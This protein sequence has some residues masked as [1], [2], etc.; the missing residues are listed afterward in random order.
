M[1]MS[2]TWALWRTYSAG[3]NDCRLILPNIFNDVCESLHSRPPNEFYETPSG[4][5][6]KSTLDNTVHG[7]KQQLCTLEALVLK[8]LSTSMKY[9]EDLPQ[10][11][12]MLQKL[13][14]HILVEMYPDRKEALKSNFANVMAQMFDVKVIREELKSNDILSP[15][16]ENRFGEMKYKLANMGPLVYLKMLAVVEEVSFL[17]FQAPESILKQVEQATDVFLQAIRQTKDLKKGGRVVSL[18]RQ[19]EQACEFV[20]EGAK[21]L[22]QHFERLHS[23]DFSGPLLHIKSSIDVEK[24]EAIMYILNSELAK[25][26]LKSTESLPNTLGPLMQL[27]GAHA[28]VFERFQVIAQIM[29]F[30]WGAGLSVPRLLSSTP[31]IHSGFA[32]DLLRLETA[33]CTW[34]V[35]SSFYKLV[36]D[37]NSFC[38]SETVVTLISEKDDLDGCGCP[39]EAYGHVGS[40]SERGDFYSLLQKHKSRAAELRRMLEGHLKSNVAKLVLNCNILATVQ[41]HQIALSEAHRCWKRA[42]SVSALRWDEFLQEQMDE[43]LNGIGPDAAR[44]KLAALWI[45]LY[46]VESFQFN[47]LPCALLSTLQQIGTF[48]LKREGEQEII[49]LNS[50]TQYDN[51]PL[52]LVLVSYC[53]EGGTDEGLVLVTHFCSRTSHKQ[54]AWISRWIEKLEKADLKIKYEEDVLRD[55]DCLGK[56]STDVMQAAL[57]CLSTLLRKLCG[58]QV[59]VESMLTNIEAMQKE[60]EELFQKKQSNEKVSHNDCA[61]ALASLQYFSQ[62]ELED[63]K[64]AANGANIIKGD[65]LPSFNGRAI[66]EAQD[67]YMKEKGEFLMKYMDK[68]A[69]RIGN[70]HWLRS[71]IKRMKSTGGWQ[72]LNE[73]E[74]DLSQESHNVEVY[75]ACHTM[76]GLAWKGLETFLQYMLWNLESNIHLF[77]KYTPELLDFLGAVLRDTLSCFCVESDSHLTMRSGTSPSVIEGHSEELKRLMGM[78]KMPPSLLS[79][80]G[81]ESIFSDIA[82][83]YKRVHDH[84][85]EDTTCTT[86]PSSQPDHEDVG[87]GCGAKSDPIEDLIGAYKEL[88]KRAQ[89]MEHNDLSIIRQISQ[90]LMALQSQ[91][92]ADITEVAMVR[93]KLDIANFERSLGDQKDR[94]W[95]ENTHWSRVQLKHSFKDEEVNVP[96]KVMAVKYNRGVVHADEQSLDRIRRKTNALQLPER[97]TLSSMQLTEKAKDSILQFLDMG[98][99]VTLWECLTSVCI[100][101][102]DGDPIQNIDLDASSTILSANLVVDIMASKGTL[103]STH[104]HI[105]ERILE[106]YSS[107]RLNFISSADGMQLLWNHNRLKFL[108]GPL[109]FLKSHLF[110]KLVE[111]QEILRYLHEF[112]FALQE[113]L[114]QYIGVVRAPVLFVPPEVYLSDPI[115]LFFP[116]KI[117]AVVQCLL[118]GVS[119]DP[120]MSDCSASFGGELSMLEDHEASSGL[121]SFKLDSENGE[122]PMIDMSSQSK[123]CEAIVKESAEFVVRSGGRECYKAGALDNGAIQMHVA[124]T[125]IS[126]TLIV[127]RTVSFDEYAEHLKFSANYIKDREAQDLEDQLTREQRT[128]QNTKSVLEHLKHERMNLEHLSSDGLVFSGELEKRK[129]ANSLC[130]LDNRISEGSR[131]CA[132]AQENCDKLEEKLK[133]K[134]LSLINEKAMKAQD[135]QKRISESMSKLLECGI[136]FLSS[137]VLEHK[138]TVCFWS[139][140]IAEKGQPLEDLLDTYSILV[141]EISENLEVFSA[142]EVSSLCKKFAQ[143]SKRNIQELEKELLELEANDPFRKCTEYLLNAFKL[144]S[145]LARRAI[146]H[147]AAV[148]EAAMRGGRSP[149]GGHT[150]LSVL[151]SITPQLSSISEKLCDHRHEVISAVEQAQDS[152]TFIDAVNNMQNVLYKC[153]DSE[154]KKLLEM[155]GYSTTLKFVQEYVG[156]FVWHHCVHLNAHLPLGTFKQKLKSRLLKDGISAESMLEADDPK[157]MET[158]RCL[159]GSCWSVAGS[160]ECHQVHALIDFPTCPLQVLWILEDAILSIGERFLP[161]AIYAKHFKEGLLKLGEAMLGNSVLQNESLSVVDALDKSVQVLGMQIPTAANIETVNLSSISELGASVEKMAKCLMVHR[162]LC[163]KFLYHFMK[164]FKALEDELTTAC[165]QTQSCCYKTAADEIESRPYS[166]NPDVEM[167]PNGEENPR[168]SFEEHPELILGN[169]TDTKAIQSVL[170]LND[171]QDKILQATLHELASALKY[172]VPGVF[173]LLVECVDGMNE[174]VA[175]Q[176]LLACY[177]EA[178]RHALETLNSQVIGHVGKDGDAGDLSVKVPGP[179][180]TTDSVLDDLYGVV[181]GRIHDGLTAHY[182]ED[183]Q[184]VSDHLVQLGKEWKESS[185]KVIEA[186][187]EEREGALRKL[188]SYVRGLFDKS[189]REKEEFDEHCKKKKYLIDLA[190]TIYN[191]CIQIGKAGDINSC[192]AM[193]RRML[194]SCRRL[195][196]SRDDLSP[197]GHGLALKEIAYVSVQSMKLPNNRMEFP[198]MLMLTCVSGG[199]PQLQEQK[200]SYSAGGFSAHFAFWVREKISFRLKL[201]FVDDNGEEWGPSKELK[202]YDLHPPRD[203][204]I[205][206]ASGATLTAKLNAKYRSCYCPSCEFSDTRIPLKNTLPS[207]TTSIGSYGGREE[208]SLA[209][210]RLMEKYSEFNALILGLCQWSM[211]PPQNAESPYDTEQREIQVMSRKREEDLETFNSLEVTQAYKK[212]ADAVSEVIAE[213]E[214]LFRKAQS[215]LRE[216]KGELLLDIVPEYAKK[217][218]AAMLTYQDCVKSFLYGKAGTSLFYE[219]HEKSNRHNAYTREMANICLKGHCVMTEAESLGCFVLNEVFYLV[220]VGLTCSALQISSL[221]DLKQLR[222]SKTKAE[223][224]FAFIVEKTKFI[225]GCWENKLKRVTHCAS[226][227]AKLSERRLQ[228][229]SRVEDL[230]KNISNLELAHTGSLAGCSFRQLGQVFFIPNSSEGFSCAPI[231]QDVDFGFVMHTDAKDKKYR[232][233]RTVTLVNK[234]ADEIFVSVKGGSGRG[235]G[236]F[237]V[238]PLGGR[239]PPGAEL[240]LECSLDPNIVGHHREAWSIEGSYTVGSPVAKSSLNLV[241]IVQKLQVAFDQNAVDFGCVPKDF[242]GEKGIK[243]RN[244]TMMPLWVKSQVQRGMYAAGLGVN[245]ESFMLGPEGEESI[246]VTVKAGAKLGSMASELVV[247]IASEKYVHSIPIQAKVVQPT[248]QLLSSQG[249]FIHEYGHVTLPIARYGQTV[250]TW[251]TLE[252][253]GLI[254]FQFQLDSRDEDMKV[255]HS[256]ADELQPAKKCIINISMKYTSRESSESVLCIIVPGCKTRRIRIK[257]CDLY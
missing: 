153:L 242:K 113:K 144:G 107:W 55:S 239:L 253:I 220:G 212:G 172:G 169:M 155:N 62:Q 109:Q 36:S 72:V 59:D 78:L 33:Y 68:A 240:H 74:R 129:I 61:D 82:D 150:T 235:S 157:L 135:A 125:L 190:S 60:L 176:D 149:S 137:W 85:E 243:I 180:T 1:L 207:E 28:R 188:L 245:R 75:G 126:T 8:T 98:V 93:Y 179:L 120:K 9:L 232:P 114:N 225:N 7:L 213:H 76:V 127:W 250:E 224:L 49:F 23:V 3:M 21:S 184:S 139:A 77:W 12:M 219:H 25:P 202:P 70:L 73:L 56:P 42:H 210:E 5:A 161:A 48:E 246:A 177:Q 206:Q 15:I 209:I 158:V 29:A 145:N 223:K 10:L 215:Y 156:M 181:N 143:E 154:A 138:D 64:K 222:K 96:E 41:W 238:L 83:E 108:L 203:L 111:A 47:R 24:Q 205:Q 80:N 18:L 230:K 182:V 121:A 254:D 251:F 54:K 38:S 234:T 257:V 16:P 132:R 40:S 88:L 244:K 171:P 95:E 14:D 52:S 2:V 151:E 165:M 252:N 146:E 204:Q 81:L 6:Q 183:L 35:K 92:G 214:E 197:E 152:S 247:G 159:Q 178:S 87:D 124:S 26:I 44:S 196:G 191:E 99:K 31:S 50:S 174:A 186:R 217:I 241:G 43:N 4:F 142:P 185:L 256:G 218:A 226:G 57:S 122:V 228:R 216:K 115:V 194:D 17:N 221:A 79:K 19:A 175:P 101:P 58:K 148:V 136:S 164:R 22:L 94:S 193:A 237:S 130:A 100:A 200:L 187:N 168:S 147:H 46:F 110:P 236:V 195:K 141:K 53:Q 39:S 189:N 20:G 63:P 227:I 66:K 201:T 173:D 117:G 71:T 90:K 248:Y 116:W 30:L 89:S 133:Q 119:L 104:L 192:D 32:L 134:R 163:I 65:I 51:H 69:N 102:M 170:A 140:E 131:T 160:V 13:V 67:C 231:H 255:S 105:A 97:R 34:K 86:Y 166:K 128:L 91:R 208:S 118:H 233:M 199:V 103:G 211:K 198:P 162:P 37:L 11:K 84:K 45:G 123:I 106:E 112:K 249:A 27:S 167:D 229:L